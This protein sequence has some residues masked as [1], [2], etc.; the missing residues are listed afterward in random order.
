MPPPLQQAT[1]DPRLCWRLLDTPEQVWVCFF[2]GYCSFLLGPGAQGSVFAL[3]ESI[4]QSCVSS[5]TSVV[6]L[7]ETS[8]K[9][10]Y[11]SLLHPEPLPL[12]QSTGDLG[13]HRRPS[14]T[15]LSQ[16]L[17]WV[18]VCTRFIWALCASLVGM[19]FY[20]KHEFAPPTIL[21]GLLLCPWTWGISL[22]PLQCHAAAAVYFNYNLL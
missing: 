12:Q 5:G 19:G 2:W 14:N 20:S 6:G 17:W 8:S 7:M 22:W 10:S 3:Q 4:S 9:R 21:L 1:T 18:L 15:V 11:P 16:S 13:L